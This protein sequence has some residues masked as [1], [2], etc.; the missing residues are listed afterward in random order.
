MVFLIDFDPKNLARG[1]EPQFHQFET[2]P[3]YLNLVKFNHL[4]HY[5]EDFEN[6]ILN[7]SPDSLDQNP[8]RKS[9]YSRFR[10]LK[11]RGTLCQRNA[12]Y[13]Q[14]LTEGAPYLKWSNHSEIWFA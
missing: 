9:I 6:Q 8:S 3:V 11:G 4:G 5:T 14:S 2:L 12:F 7:L 1:Q 10:P 13:K